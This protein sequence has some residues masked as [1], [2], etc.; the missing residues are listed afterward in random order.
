MCQVHWKGGQGARGQ[1]KSRTGA[2]APD[3]IIDVPPGTVVRTAEGV[4]A[5]QLTHEG[6][7]SRAQA[8]RKRRSPC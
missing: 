5:G 6:E 1:G 3:V 8:C 4:L 2:S 7:V